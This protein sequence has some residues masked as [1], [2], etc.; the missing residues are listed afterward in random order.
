MPLGRVVSS[1]LGSWISRRGGYLRALQLDNNAGLASLLS[2][3]HANFGD[4]KKLF[5]ELD[6]FDKVTTDDVQRVARKY[7]TPENK[8]VALTVQPEEGKK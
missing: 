6:E 4:W 3:Y 5:N 1:I 7:F 8:T 2:S